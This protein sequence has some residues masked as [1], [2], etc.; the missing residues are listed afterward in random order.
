MMGVIRSTMVGPSMARPGAVRFLS[1]S[2]A[3]SL[4]FEK[5]LRMFLAMV[6]STHFWL[7]ILPKNGIK[8]C[9]LNGGIILAFSNFSKNGKL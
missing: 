7:K 6:K 2:L 9:N 3:G 5:C 4:G 8:A 1:T